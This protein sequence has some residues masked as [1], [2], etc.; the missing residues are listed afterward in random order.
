[1]EDIDKE[2]FLNDIDLQDIVCF[3]LI[4]IGEFAGKLS[5]NFTSNNYNIPWNQIKSLRN[6]IVHSY[7]IIDLEKLW[8][9]I[10]YDINELYTFCNMILELEK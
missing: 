10:T 3:N 5:N 1:M 9:T 4:Q 8:N 7:G 6:I 2:N